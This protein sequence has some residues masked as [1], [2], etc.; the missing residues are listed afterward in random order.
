[1]NH[2]NKNDQDILYHD[3]HHDHGWKF[4]NEQLAKKID[5]WVYWGFLV[6]KL[7]EAIKKIMLIIM[8]Y[9]W[10]TNEKQGV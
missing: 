4:E 6:I 8:S 5:W 3:N 9:M 2:D 7:I 1:M 10:F